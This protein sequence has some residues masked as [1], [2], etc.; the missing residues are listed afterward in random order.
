MTDKVMVHATH[1]GHKPQR[2]SELQTVAPPV[3]IYE[4]DSE[5]L[6]VTDFPAVEP[7]DVSVR[8][9][10]GQLDI[11]G[12]QSYSGN[13]D[14]SLLPVLFARIFRVPDTIDPQGVSAELKNG[15]LRITL[16]KS[17]EAKPRRIKVVAG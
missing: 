9:E 11:E 6:V 13:K 15:V 8:L 12:R 16:K 7:G 14:E 1:E 2:L 17:E 5:I 3:D 10:G 4:N